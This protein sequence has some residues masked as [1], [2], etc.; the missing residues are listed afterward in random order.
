MFFDLERCG[1]CVSTFVAVSEKGELQV[2]FFESKAALKT[3][4]R[5]K[6]EMFNEIDYRLLR[7]KI[8]LTI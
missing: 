7:V 4:S 5:W 3:F 1:R 8:K 2:D 6:V